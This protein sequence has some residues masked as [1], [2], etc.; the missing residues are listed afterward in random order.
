MAESLIF[1]QLFDQTSATFS[2]LLADADSGA[3]VFIDTVYERHERDLS[4]V[5]ELELKL[6]ACLEPTVTPTTSP[7]PG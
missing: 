4:L 7:A 1:K 2:Y 6:L 3:A 5:R